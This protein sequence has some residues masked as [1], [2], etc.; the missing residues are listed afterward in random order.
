ML[1]KDSSFFFRLQISNRKIKIIPLSNLTSNRSLNNTELLVCG[2]LYKV[3]IFTNE[4]WD[5]DKNVFYLLNIITSITLWIHY[6]FVIMSVLCIFVLSKFLQ[7]HKDASSINYFLQPKWFFSSF[8]YF[9]QQNSFWSITNV[10]SPHSR[11]STI[12]IGSVKLYI[13]SHW[14]YESRHWHGFLENLEIA[15]PATQPFAYRI[16]IVP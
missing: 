15:L 10:S 7:T 16:I 8:S 1:S 11:I 12:F 6:I 5:I 3:H 14:D 13:A 9:L 2:Y 4:K